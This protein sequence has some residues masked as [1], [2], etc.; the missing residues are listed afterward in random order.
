[1]KNKKILQTAEKLG[2]T[3][4]HSEGFRRGGYGEGI[5]G[6]WLFYVSFINP[7]DGFEECDGVVE[8]Y[9]VED[10]IEQMIKITKYWTSEV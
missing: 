1:M 2:L 10:A 4:T 7:P 9:N 5:P 8:A 6:M 3:I